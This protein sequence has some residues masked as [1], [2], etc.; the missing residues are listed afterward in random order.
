MKRSIALVVGLLAVL[1]CRD[2]S[3]ETLGPAGEADISGQA[4][5]FSHTSNPSSCLDKAL[6]PEFYSTSDGSPCDAGT[7]GNE[8]TNFLSPLRSTSAADLDAL[9][10]D[11]LPHL[12]VDVLCISRDTEVQ[13][14]PSGDP[15]AA[16][17]DCR[18]FP[19]LSVTTDGSAFQAKFRTSKRKDPPNAA[20]QVLIYLDVGDGLLLAWRTVGLT[21]DPSID[22]P[23]DDNLFVAQNG[24]TNPIQFHIS[25]AISDCPPDAPITVTCLIGNGGGTLSVFDPQGQVTS[26][27]NI[28]PNNGLNL[29]TLSLTGCTQLDVDLRRFGCAVEINSETF[30]ATNGLL[31]NSS[32]TICE[33]LSGLTAD[34]IAAVRVAQ[35]DE[36]GQTILPEVPATDI[37]TE[38]AASLSS[39]YAPQ[40]IWENAWARVTDFVGVQSADAAVG[41]KGGGGGDIKRLS[42]VQLVLPVRVDVI[43]ETLP[44]GPVRLGDPVPVDL[45]TL[46][47]TDAAAPGT[48]LRVYGDGSVTC[49]TT[50]PAGTNAACVDDGT[51]GPGQ[52]VVETGDAGAQVLFRPN[53]VGTA[54][55]DV[56]GCGVAVPGQPD[57]YSGLGAF[58]VL[59]ELNGADGC[60]RLRT[61][62]TGFHN[63]PAVGLDPFGDDTHEVAI[64]DRRFRIPIPVCDS[65]TTAAVDGIKESAWECAESVQFPVNLPGAGKGGSPPATLLWMNDADRLYLGVMVPRESDETDTSLWFEFDLGRD[66]DRAT[67]E[68]DANDDLIGVIRDK[69]D[70]ADPGTGAFGTPQDRYVDTGCADNSGSSVCDP[71][72]PEGSMDVTAGVQWDAASGFIF[73]ELS[74]PLD[75]GDAPYDFR[76]K[77]GDAVGLFVRLAIGSGAQGKT[78]WPGFRMFEDPTAGS[79]GPPIIIEG[80]GGP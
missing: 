29:F 19:D 76:L 13:W 23:S 41:V 26:A 53:A 28:G 78:N 48:I 43:S 66:G 68:P 80:P 72:T 65:Q 27:L 5:S 36:Q 7:T 38:C 21:D 18:D 73:Y 69:K 15:R 61:D 45:Q 74:H 11:L 51:A 55:V 67:P 46:T 40:G 33:D 8:F 34:Q 59:G 1:S 54:Y 25:Q 79:P 30:D 22:T 35:E 17:P 75:S 39:L 14:P 70:K 60:D 58:D 16:T 62:E 9:A 37:Q 56:L 52:V 57:A 3:L 50:P 49:P 77:P 71:S 12:R 2:S 4:P 31:E 10:A 20:Y 44:E 64:N 47:G 6:H 63:G 32:V 24:S 42:D